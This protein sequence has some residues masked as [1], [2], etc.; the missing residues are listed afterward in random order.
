MSLRQLAE[1]DASKVT[2]PANAKQAA[3]IFDG[4]TKLIGRCSTPISAPARPSTARSSQRRRGA[5]RVGPTE[6]DG[7]GSRRHGWSR[8]DHPRS[9]RDRGAQRQ[10][11]R[12]AQGDADLRVRADG[13]FERAIVGAL[14]RRFARRRS[15]S[16]RPRRAIPATRIWSP[17]SRSARL[18]Q[19]AVGRGDEHC[20]D[21]HGPCAQPDVLRAA[22]RGRLARDHRRLGD[23][24]DCVAWLTNRWITRPLA[25]LAD[26]AAAM[27]GKRLPAAVQEILESPVNETIASPPS[28]PCR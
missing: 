12:Q 17:C 25:R 23:A 28:S 7:V 8:L 9:G 21:R 5:E 13:P 26:Q 20:I 14:D 22:R 19:S 24:R 27:A 15:P 6:R 4:Y 18:G 1:D 11:D 16:C 3:T 10:A 2:S